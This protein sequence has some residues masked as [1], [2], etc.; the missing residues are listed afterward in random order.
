MS[1]DKRI[2]ITGGGG[3]IGSMLA[4]R[5]AQD[6]EVTLFDSRFDNNAYALSGLKG[7]GRVRI[8]HGDILDKD[9]V[10]DVVRD[11]QIVIHTAAVLGVQKVLSNSIQTLRVN[12]EGTSNLLDAASSSSRCERV[13]A[14]STSEVFGANAFRV[15]EDGDS[16]LTSIQDAR[17]C[18]AISKLAAESLAFGYHREKGLPV[19]V[20]RPFN[21]FGPGRIG[22]YV[23]LRFVLNALRSKALSVHGEGTQ[24]RAWCYIDDF[25]DGVLRCVDNERAVGQAF[26]IGNPRN[27]ITIYD[28]A[29][30]IVSLCGSKS[31]IV[32]QP[33]NFKDIDV[34]VPDIAKARSTL[35][36]NPRVE[37]DEGLTRTIAWIKEHLHLFAAGSAN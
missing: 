34:R 35:G 32:S 25:C 1:K 36:F 24:I 12:Y 37:M 7:N 17:W 28:L 3:F 11:A 30:R 31:E 18:Y 29:K 26:N 15:A 23:V 9:A 2:V 4:M 33:I 20:V 13:I 8:V 6:N 10:R 14:F 16:L 5:M 19:V 22:D 21:V 27:T